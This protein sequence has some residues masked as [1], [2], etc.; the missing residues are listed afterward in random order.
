MEFRD[1]NRI[2]TALMVT[3]IVAAVLQV[4][5]APQVSILGG[6]INFMAVLAGTTALRGDTRTAVFTGF[7]SGLF[8]DL[9]AVVP[10]GVM[11]LLLTVGS[12][13]LASASG[14]GASGLTGP[15]IQMFAV[16]AL[17]V[18]LV[19]GIVLLIMGVEGDF[20]T[21]LFGHGLAS[22]GLTTLV[23]AVFLMFQGPGDAGRMG[24][25]SSRAGKRFKG[26]R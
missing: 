26:S 11:A 17:A 2:H 19:N 8:Y 6:R 1:T 9:T 21:A 23:A 7:F 22:A 15:S 24:F 14:A 3:A 16:F 12:F 4:A 5:L 20:V 18:S 25:G 10:V 13:A